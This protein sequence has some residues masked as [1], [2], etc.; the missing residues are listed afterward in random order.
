VARHLGA[1]LGAGESAVTAKEVE[2][3]MDADQ[4]AECRIRPEMPELYFCPDLKG[5]GWCFRKGHYLNIG[6]GSEQAHGLSSTLESFCA[7]LEH[8]GRIPRNV[9]DKFYGHAYLLHGR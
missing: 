5:Y 2:F 4:V 1:E 6:L 9:P 8:R 3:E 7:F